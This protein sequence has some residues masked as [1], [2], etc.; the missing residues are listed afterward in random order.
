M[1][2]LDV[3][4]CVIFVGALIIGYTR[5][6]ISQMVSL[7][8]LIIAYVVAY[9]FY[10]Q[11]APWVGRLL[12]VQTF[13][14]Y[15]KYEFAIQTLHL[16]VYVINAISF[17]ILFFAVKVALSVVGRLLNIVAKVPGLNLLNRLSGTLLSLMEVTVLVVIVVQI[18]AIMPSDK[19][20]AIFKDSI[21]APYFVDAWMYFENKI[22][23]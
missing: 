13:A 19:V 5:G 18:M 21:T 2:I 11:L 16:N 8:G 23:E 14:A 9:K 4:V 22:S 17:A 7:L 1:N 12:P 3:S 20:Q 6:F 10:D 15:S